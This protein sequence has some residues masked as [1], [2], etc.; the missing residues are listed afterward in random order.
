MRNG[1]E[2]LQFHHLV[3]EMRLI[4]GLVPEKRDRKKIDYPLVD[5]I[6]AGLAM[7]FWQD[8]GVLPFQQRLEDQ[9]GASNLR[10]MFGIKKVPKDTQFRNLLDPIE[11][12][13]ILAGLR[14]GITLLEGTRAWLEFRTLDGRYLV[15]IDAT[16]YFHSE[17]LS[18]DCCLERRHKDG[19]VEYYHQILVASLI[20]P[21]TGQSFPLCAEEIRREDGQTKQDCET[22]A[23][24][25]L[26]PTLAKLY[27]HLDIVLIADSLYSKTPIMEL[28]LALKMNYLFVAKPGDHPHLFEQLQGLRLA[29]AVTVIEQPGKGKAGK[30][31]YEF[32]HDVPVFATT[33]ITSHWIS[34]SELGSGKKKPYH[35]GW[36]TNIKPTPKNVAPL[37]TGGRHRWS[38]ENQTFNALK[39]QGYHFE[40]N[41]GH[42][43][44]HLRFNFIL[45]NLLAFLMHQLLSIG[46][47]L[48]NE[49][50]SWKGAVKEF[51]DHIR[52]AI[53]LALWPD[54]LT[55][56]NSFLGRGPKLRLDTG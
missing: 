1:P 39:N 6:S 13:L 41:F 43:K 31:I 52:W 49:A 47:A 9:A 5:V 48:Y 55:L 42:G 7:M 56:L 12:R 32:A 10:T 15:A 53:R 11:P 18:C 46:D 40:H 20:H 22:N 54:W 44:K 4:F 29:E 30:Q 26:L 37:A 27:C 35:N 21:I 14:R 19:R 16:E 17:N 25:R 28:V 45:L 8:P 34:F 2:Q 3:Q 23:A 50:K 38:I 33:Q 51:L 36:L 24:Y